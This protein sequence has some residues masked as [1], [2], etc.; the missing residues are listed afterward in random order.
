MDKKELKKAISARK[1]WIISTLRRASYRYAPRN[2]AQRLAR[3]DRGL[4]KCAMCEEIF[5]QKE[6]V[7]DHIEP[8]VHL[9]NGWTNWDDFVN[10]LFCNV[11][12]FQILCHGCHDIKTSQEDSIRASYNAER[13]DLEKKTIKEAKKLAKIKKVE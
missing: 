8:V 13:K 3:V 7:I 9:K 12:G 2:E 6:T 4:Y 10:R 1:N 5:H 11:E